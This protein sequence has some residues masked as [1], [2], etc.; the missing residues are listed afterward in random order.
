LLS[1]RLFGELA[2]WRADA[3]LPSLESARARSLLGYL[4][5]HGESPHARE[6]LAFLLWPTQ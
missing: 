5:L 1:V 3:P 6:R 4:I 2:L